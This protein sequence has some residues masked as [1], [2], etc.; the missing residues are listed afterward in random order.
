MDRKSVDNICSTSHHV[1]QSVDLPEK[2]EFFQAWGWMEWKE[3]NL[4]SARRLYQ[5]ALAIDTTTESAARC[6][7]VI[8]L[9][10]FLQ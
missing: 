4:A 3:G 8:E 5:K 10:I 6:L 7:Q 2:I 1:A 9:E